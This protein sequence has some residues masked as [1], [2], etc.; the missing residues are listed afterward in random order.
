M[1]HNKEDNKGAR[2][3]KQLSPK[4]KPPLSYKGGFYCF[5]EFEN[6]N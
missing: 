6:T 5:Y 2:F 4:Q 3:F 1:F